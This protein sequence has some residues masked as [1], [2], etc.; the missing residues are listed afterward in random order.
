M[1]NAM[2]GYGTVYEIEDSPA[3]TDTFTAMAEVS[4]VAFPDVQVEEVDVTHFESPGKFREFIAGLQDGG[5]AGFTINWVAGD[6]T[7][8]RIFELKASGEVV[9]HRIT[10]PNDVTFTFPGFVKGFTPDVPIDGKISAEVTIRVAG[11]MVEGAAA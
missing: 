5:D 9:K 10:L 7:S 3:G 6:A 11:E 2:I 8:D 4:A 1:S